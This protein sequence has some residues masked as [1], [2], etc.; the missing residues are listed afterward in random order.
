MALLLMPFAFTGFAAQLTAT[1]Q[2]G[3]KFTPF[4]G[5]DAFK[6]A[7]AAAVDGDII[8]LSAGV[9]NAC[10][11]T[12]SV[13][14]IGVY[15][16]SNDTAKIT[17]FNANMTISADNVTIEGVQSVR[18]IIKGADQLTLNRCQI[19]TIS[20]EAKVNHPYHN[21]TI[22]TDC[23]V[24]N[25]SAMTLSQN[26]VLRNCYINHFSDSNTSTNPALIENC[27]I[28][29]FVCYRYDGILSDSCSCPHAIYR[30][31]ILGFYSSII[32][33]YTTTPSVN[34]SSPS[35]FHNN[36]LA[37]SYFLPSANSN[38]R[39][40]NISFGSCVTSN[41]S[42]KS[43]YDVP[44]SNDVYRT[45]SF[46]PDGDCGPQNHKEYPAIPAIT[47]SEIDTQTDAEG[48]LHV[49]ITAT[50]RD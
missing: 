26:A 29:L 16:F 35:E 30:N 46:E 17:K 10:E 1:L 7:H 50:A 14:I 20:D 36:I 11:I 23:F 25:F 13:S 38:L 19:V 21:N 3:D 40:W 22:L 41:N 9:F 43:F 39:R 18:T 42:S 47:S 5:A 31:C 49:K 48:V 45:D 37:T 15:G 2:S 34:F 4:Y 8:T 28:P 27:N 12:K 6:N 33:G 32:A 24:Y 44:S